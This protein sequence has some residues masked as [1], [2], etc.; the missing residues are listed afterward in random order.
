MICG[1]VDRLCTKIVERRSPEFTEFLSKARADLRGRL[2]QVDQRLRTQIVDN[3]RMKFEFLN[4]PPYLLLSALG[5]SLA[6]WPLCKCK[7]GVRRCIQEVRA[8]EADGRGQAL[9][10]VTVFFLVGANNSLRAEL[11][12]FASD[13]DMS[14]PSAVAWELRQ[15]AL[16]SVI[17]RRAEGT[18]SHISMWQKKELADARARAR[19]LE[20]VIP[21]QRQME[22]RLDGQCSYEWIPTLIQHRWAIQRF[23]SWEEGKEGL[24]PERWAL[25]EEPGHRHRR[26]H[27]RF[28][29]APEDRH[30]GGQHLEHAEGLAVPERA[31]R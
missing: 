9:H 24:G 29:G 13:P 20:A 12:A 31:G 27:Q 5:N 1:G 14:L 6:D 18:H 22:A 26:H 17:T 7:E 15:Y 28:L 10:R 19:G 23:E 2:L 4:R 16:G 3:W 21:T 8:A 30:G 11:E 25:P